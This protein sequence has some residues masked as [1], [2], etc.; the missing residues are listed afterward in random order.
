MFCL[1]SV[2]RHKNYWNNH[3]KKDMCLVERDKAVQCFNIWTYANVYTYRFQL[4]YQLKLGQLGRPN[5]M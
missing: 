3:V 4:I 5:G 1:V 2:D